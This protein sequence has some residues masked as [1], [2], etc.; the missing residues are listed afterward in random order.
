MKLAGTTAQ[1]RGPDRS[2][3]LSFHDKFFDGRLRPAAKLFA[4]RGRLKEDYFDK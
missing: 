3:A 1:P 4:A 2:A